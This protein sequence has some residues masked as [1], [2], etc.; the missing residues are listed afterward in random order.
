MAYLIASERRGK[1]F[2]RIYGLVPE[3]QGRTLAVTVLYVPSWLVS[4]RA[5][6]RQPFPG[7]VAFG[8]PACAMS[9]Y[10]R[11]LQSC[12][13]LYTVLQPFVYLYSPSYSCTSLYIVVQ[14]DT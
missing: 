5:F 6:A 10:K 12:T 3:S 9:S 4:D 7:H 8:T 14:P 11:M 1:N 13:A 2:N